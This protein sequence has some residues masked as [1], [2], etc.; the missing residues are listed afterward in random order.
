MVTVLQKHFKSI[1]LT[2]NMQRLC[3]AGRCISRQIAAVCT[4]TACVAPGTVAVALLGE[5]FS[6]RQL[7]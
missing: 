3:T 2:C 1:S 7:W 5:W 6:S 4:A